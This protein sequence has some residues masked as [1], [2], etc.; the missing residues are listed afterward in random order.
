MCRCFAY[1]TICLPHAVETGRPKR[2]QSLAISF[3]CP[4]NPGN[5]ACVFWKSSVPNCSAI[6]PAQQTASDSYVKCQW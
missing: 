6:S 3:L 1:M 4:V 5:R 2:C